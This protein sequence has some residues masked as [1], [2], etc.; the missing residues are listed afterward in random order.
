[1]SEG[2]NYAGG[3][4]HIAQSFVVGSAA[5]LTSV[6]I[7]F[8]AVPS[9]G[10]AVVT[11]QSPDSL[12]PSNPGTKVADLTLSGTLSMGANTFNAPADTE[13]S[14]GTYFVVVERPLATGVSLSLGE[15]N[16]PETTALTGWSIADNLRHS[17][18]DTGWSNEP[19]PFSMA[20][21]GIGTT[22]TNTAA[23]GQPGFPARR[24]SARR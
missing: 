17:L 23:M 10:T 4:T 14:T 13:L 15:G 11:L 19:T 18:N 5:T 12:Y 22:T 8:F 7:H 24:R 16:V 2:L 9:G 21:K 1:M 6:E 20:V 3:R